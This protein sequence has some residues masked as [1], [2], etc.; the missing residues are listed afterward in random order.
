MSEPHYRVREFY[1]TL[2]HPSPI[3]ESLPNGWEPFA[4]LPETVWARDI[5]PDWDAGTQL[6]VVVARLRVEPLP[7]TR[8]TS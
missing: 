2:G 7:E 3:G 1:L 6:L 5:N 4:V 8:D